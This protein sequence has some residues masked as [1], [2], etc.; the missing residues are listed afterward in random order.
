MIFLISLNV[1]SSEG[2]TWFLETVDSDIGAGYCCSI[3]IDSNDNLHVSY[4]DTVNNSLKYAKWNGS[5]WNIETVDSADCG[6][7]TSIAVDSSGYPHIS[8]GGDFS[9]SDLR[10]A[11]WNGSSWDIETIDSSG[12]EWF[13]SIVL[14]SNEYPHIS[15]CD[16]TV[17]YLKYAQWNGSDWDIENVDSSG[18]IDQQTSIVLDSNDYPHFSYN[19]DTNENLLYAKWDGSTFAYTI[20]DS[21]GSVGRDSCITLDSNEYP[22]ISYQDTGNRKVKYAQWNGSI[23][24][25]IFAPIGGGDL[26]KDNTSIVL[27]D[28]D[29]AYIS[30]VNDSAA[31]LLFARWNGS[32]WDWVYSPDT[33][34]IV[35]GFNGIAFDSNDSLY[36]VYNSTTPNLMLAKFSP[37]LNN[38]SVKG[39]SISYCTLE[40]TA[41]GINS[42]H[43]DEY[44][45]RYSESNITELNWGSATQVSG[46]TIP[47]NGGSTETFTVSGLAQDT[48]YYFAIKFRNDA[49]WSDLS[50]VVSAHTGVIYGNG[51]QTISF[52]PNDGYHI[53]DWVVNVKLFNSGGATAVTVAVEIVNITDWVIIDDAASVYSDINAGQELWSAEGQPFMF[54]LT[55]RPPSTNYIMIWLKITYT[56]SGKGISSEII[57]LKLEIPGKDSS[58]PKNFTALSK[59]SFIKLRWQEVNG[60]DGYNVYRLSG[61]YWKNINHK[62][63]T[64]NS[65]NDENVIDGIEYSYKVTS[66]TGTSESGFSAVAKVVF[67]EEY[68]TLDEIVT[69]PNPAKDKVTFSKLPKGSKITIYTLTGELVYTLE[70]KD[71]KSDWYLINKAGKK[72]SN[73]IYYYVIKHKNGNKTG[74]VA[75]VR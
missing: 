47:K 65:F 71:S 29:Y 40:W 23:W 44:D 69:Y 56:L 73:G 5:S 26:T 74:K 67:K 8:Y 42:N 75:I 53:S 39:T 60:V 54:D 21:G 38:L 16:V 9:N 14:D 45:I 52:T 57:S 66:V 7:C 12:D 58:V 24:S 62:L 35:G 13:T 64:D 10:Y 33:S 48:T 32:T 3:A 20:V 11:K 37:T 46:E 17:G 72:V 1:Y 68:E 34:G 4:W 28:N 59:D 25:S 61:D 50:D 55:N 22:H 41:P 2:V 49:S 30:Y 70:V 31:T 27:D 51:T 15:Y 43:A 18:N 19:D 63:V 36:I 6:L